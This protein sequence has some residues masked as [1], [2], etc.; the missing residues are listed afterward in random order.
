MARKLNYTTI[1]GEKSRQDFENGCGYVYGI[2]P[3]MRF[4]TQKRNAF[5]RASLLA[6]RTCSVPDLQNTATTIAPCLAISA[7]LLLPKSLKREILVSKTAG[8]LANVG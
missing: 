2:W 7:T 6:S 1:L 4:D 5:E 8:N 3:G